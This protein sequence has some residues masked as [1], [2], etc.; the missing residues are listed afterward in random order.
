[1]ID[2]VLYPP[3]SLEARHRPWNLEVP[4]LPRIGDSFAYDHHH[5]YPIESVQ[6]CCPKERGGYRC[7]IHVK[8]GTKPAVVAASNQPTRVLEGH[9]AKAPA[10]SVL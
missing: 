7:E 5:S 3:K 9:A 2:I 6:F 8:L 4:A 1:M 10:K